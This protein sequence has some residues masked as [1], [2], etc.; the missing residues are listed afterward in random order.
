MINSP[1]YDGMAWADA[2]KKITAD[3]AAKGVAKATV[4]YKLRDWLFSRQRYWGEPFPIV[5]VNEADY[6]KAKAARGAAL[7]AEPVT[8]VENGKKVFAL[9]LPAGALPLALPDVQSFL[10]SGN[11]ESPLAN[12]PEWLEIWF[13]H[14]TGE[15]VP[16]SQAKPAG[17][18]WL[19]GRCE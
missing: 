13:N 11:G 15:A 16:A 19:R 6:A 7:P 5:W 17:E 12:V 14:E 18:A 8:F 3:L 9:P 4:N 1:G 2:K 10:P